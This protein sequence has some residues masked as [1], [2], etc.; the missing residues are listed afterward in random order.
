[1]SLDAPVLRVGIQAGLIDAYQ[2]IMELV[3]EDPTGNPHRFAAATMEVL[4]WILA[5]TQPESPQ[6]A[7]RPFARPLRDRLVAEAVRLIWTQGQ[8]AI[9]VSDVVANFPVTRRSLERRFQRCLGRTILDEIVRCR[10]ERA[11]RLLL[12]T[13]QPLKA[14]ALAAGF[15]N[16]RHMSRVFHR[17]EGVTPA[18]YRRAQ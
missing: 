10:L 17:A 14:V 11:K 13:D 12:E 6:P 7:S 15:S 9:S 16:A 18:N 1:L 3:S 8:H 2:R 5:P 4:A